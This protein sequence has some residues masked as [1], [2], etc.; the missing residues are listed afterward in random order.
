MTISEFKTKCDAFKKENS[1]DRISLDLKQAAV[2][3]F[4]AGVSFEIVGKACGFTALSVANWVR[5]SKKFG[6]LKGSATKN[7]STP[8]TKRPVTLVRQSPRAAVTIADLTAQ[9]NKL[10]N[11][12]FE[13]FCKDIGIQ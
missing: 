1:T 2:D 8:V 6:P 12:L 3:L 10:K 11:K 5:A 9:N 13:I 7:H 4:N